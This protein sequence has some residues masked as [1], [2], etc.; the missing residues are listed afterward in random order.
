[1]LTKTIQY[2]IHQINQIVYN[3]IQ[4]CHDNEMNENLCVY[5][6]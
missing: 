4:S 6:Q 2:D 5:S 1:M 3:F